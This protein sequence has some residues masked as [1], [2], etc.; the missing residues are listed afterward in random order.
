MPHIAIRR[1]LVPNISRAYALD[2]SECGRAPNYFSTSA[3]EWFCLYRAQNL[4]DNAADPCLSFAKCKTF[5][6]CHP[7]DPSVAPGSIEDEPAATAL[8]AAH[9]KAQRLLGPWASP[10]VKFERWALEHVSRDDA[11]LPAML[12]RKTLQ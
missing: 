3:L 9:V 7:T 2:V 6:D 11:Q 12:K 5:G 10:V 1:Y 8:L 4:A